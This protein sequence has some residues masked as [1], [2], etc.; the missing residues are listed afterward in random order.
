[1]ADKYDTWRIERTYTTLTIKDLK[2]TICTVARHDQRVA[3]LIR[4]APLMR[5]ALEALNADARPDNWDDPGIAEGERSAWR[6]LD[7]ALMSSE[8]ARSDG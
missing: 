4:C 6:L 1:M 5:A 2:R 8:E 7:I 3:R